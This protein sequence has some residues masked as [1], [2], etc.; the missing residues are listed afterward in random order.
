[1]TYDDIYA[2]FDPLR[3]DIG[4]SD[5]IQSQ[6]FGLDL[7]LDIGM[8]DDDNEGTMDMDETLS[9]IE[10]GRDA[11]GA[12]RHVR[13]SIGSGFGAGRLSAVGDLSMGQ[14]DISMGADMGM[15]F[16]PQ[17]DL[18]LDI[19]MDIDD[20]AGRFADDIGMGGMGMDIDE[21][22][23]AG[24]PGLSPPGEE[25]KSQECESIDQDSSCPLD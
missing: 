12:R 22:L 3:R 15:E 5:G 23:M 25:K 16:E 21:D 24:V 19:G 6:Y 13:E 14:G 10:V 20:A 2:P 11:A 9:A 1:M 8:H 4:P 18:G 17:M 7:G